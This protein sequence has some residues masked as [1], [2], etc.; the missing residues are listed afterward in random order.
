MDLVEKLIAESKNPK[1]EDDVQ[2]YDMN[3]LTGLRYRLKAVSGHNCPT[4]DI[5]VQHKAEARVAKMKQIKACKK[6]CCAS[7]CLL[8]SHG[9]EVTELDDKVNAKQYLFDALLD[10]SWT[11]FE[12][13][14]QQMFDD[15]PIKEDKLMSL[16]CAVNTNLT[17]VGASCC[18]GP[19]CLG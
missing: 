5:G 18:G 12:E 3:H 13:Y 15:L 11:V 19:V 7:H 14:K 2:S 9:K 4:R 6:C 10:W 1:V 16:L 17:E 8:A